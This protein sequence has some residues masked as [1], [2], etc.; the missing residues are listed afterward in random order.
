MMSHDKNCNPVMKDNR[1]HAQVAKQHHDIDG[2]NGE[3]LDYDK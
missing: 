2:L 1:T 3:M